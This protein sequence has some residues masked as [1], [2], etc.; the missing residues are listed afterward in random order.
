MFS[1][2]GVL[3]NIHG[4]LRKA[5]ALNL[6]VQCLTEGAILNHFSGKIN[7]FEPLKRVVKEIESGKAV[8]GLVQLAGNGVPGKL[9]LRG[10]D[11]ATINVLGIVGAALLVLLLAIPIPMLFAYRQG[12][13]AKVE[14]SYRH[15]VME[16]HGIQNCLEVPERAPRIICR[17]AERRQVKESQSY[18][19]DVVS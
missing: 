1:I 4:V 18:I 6:A 8:A 7:I 2:Q 14:S 12:V 17:R 15:A 9:V 10:S 19:P 5:D 16:I 3:R 11:V 13:D